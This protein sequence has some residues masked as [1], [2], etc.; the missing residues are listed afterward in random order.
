MPRILREDAERL[1]GDVP[2]E[3]TFWCCDDRIL[4]NVK[5][6]GE[7]LASMTDETFARHSNADK[8]DFGKW[9]NDVIGDAKLARDL[10]KSSSQVQAARKVAERVDFLSAKLA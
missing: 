9:V 3:K 4:R 5:E 1:L 10:A 7:A 8:S 2:K 6:L